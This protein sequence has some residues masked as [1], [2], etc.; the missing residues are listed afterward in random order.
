MSKSAKIVGIGAVAVLAV[1]ASA[2][3]AG[4]NGTQRYGS[5]GALQIKVDGKIYQEAINE[6]TVRNGGEIKI[7]HG[8]HRGTIY[9]HGNS[10][11]IS[12]SGASAVISVNSI[13][14]DDSSRPSVTTSDIK[15]LSV[16]KAR[17]EN[18]GKITTGNIIGHGNSVSISASGATS[19]IAVT[20]INDTRVASLSTGKITQVAVNTDNVS[21]GGT[22]LAGKITGNG[23]SVS[24]GASGA[25]A[26]ISVSITK[27]WG[28]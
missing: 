20:S 24:I 7:K 18:G 25:T 4:N 5:Q 13:L 3:F 21:N 1:S 22:I 27:G 6:D 10:A 19:A 17:V 26:G 11:N 12:A 9:G 15:Q 14:N 23:N 8:Y 16:N 2:A 28:N